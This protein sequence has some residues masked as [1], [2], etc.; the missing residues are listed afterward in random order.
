M[1][2]A[3]VSGVAQTLPLFSN[4]KSNP[5]QEKGASSLVADST[6]ESAP[7][8]ADTVSISSQLR[9]PM[10]DVKKEQAL[11]EEAKKEKVKR[12][13]AKTANSSEKSDRAPAKVQFV[14]DLKGELSVRYM[15]TA[16][17]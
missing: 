16:C 6:K 2:P 13:D 8:P 12:E 3:E 15:D 1:A 17:L 11:I 10:I 7:F 9:Q 14:Y 4:A 5:P